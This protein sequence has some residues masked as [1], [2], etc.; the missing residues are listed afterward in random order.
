MKKYSPEWS[1]KMRDV[2][3]SVRYTLSTT[4]K[5]KKCNIVDYIKEALIEKAESINNTAAQDKKVAKPSDYKLDHIINLL[6][7][8]N[9]DNIN[10]QLINIISYITKSLDNN[11]GIK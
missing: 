3:D 7:S 2:P 10:P 9:N 1:I 6:E 11:N 8:S 4:A 5:N